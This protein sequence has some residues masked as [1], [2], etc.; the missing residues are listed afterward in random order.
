LKRAYRL[1]AARPEPVDVGNDLFGRERDTERGDREIVAAQTQDRDAQDDRE[2][3]RE[4]HR[5][6]D[7]ERDALLVPMLP[8]RRRRIRADAE[9]DDVAEADVTGVAAEDVPAEAERGEHQ[10]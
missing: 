6:P 10:H 3:N 1:S 2:R 9:K 5:D 7:R 8:E 4:D